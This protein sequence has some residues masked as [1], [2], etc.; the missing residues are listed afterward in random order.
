MAEKLNGPGFGFRMQAA[1]QQV[2]LAQVGQLAAD[3]MVRREHQLHELLS[4]LDGQAQHS[5]YAL[6]ED[7]YRD[8]ATKL[9]EILGAPK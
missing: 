3:R 1:G 2:T 6:E 8:A 9:R 4:Y 7:A 5:G